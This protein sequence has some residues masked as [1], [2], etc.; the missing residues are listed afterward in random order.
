MAAKKLTEAQKRMSTLD[1]LFQ[2]GFK[3]E[4]AITDMTIEQILGIDGLEVS[5]MRLIS[6]LQ[7]AVKNHKVVSFLS[8]GDDSEQQSS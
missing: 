2:A 6:E 1:A 5:E 7:K 3:S 8:G 4:K